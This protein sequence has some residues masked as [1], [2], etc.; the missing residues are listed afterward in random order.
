MLC[1]LIDA[2]VSQVTNVHNLTFAQAVHFG[3]A[4]QLEICL[5]QHIYKK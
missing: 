3:E 2:S 1:L 5:Y 4:R